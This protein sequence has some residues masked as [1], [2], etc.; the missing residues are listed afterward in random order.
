MFVLGIGIELEKWYKATQCLKNESAH[1]TN[2][3]RTYSL[4]G[5]LTSKSMLL[6]QALDEL[7][8]SLL[9]VLWADL[10]VD[11]LL[12]RGAL[13][14]LLQTVSVGYPS[15]LLVAD[16]GSCLHAPLFFTKGTQMDKSRRAGERTFISNIPGAVVCSNG[17]SWLP[18]LKRP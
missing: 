18:C 2:S 13:G 17:G 16:L 7:D 15:G 8:V 3:S 9:R 6:L 14:F 1:S 10:L 5:A 4:K 12:P 11:Q